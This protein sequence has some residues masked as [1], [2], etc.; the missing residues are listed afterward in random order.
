MTQSR[1]LST[2]IYCLILSFWKKTDLRVQSTRSSFLMTTSY[3]SRVQLVIVV[4]DLQSA[5]LGRVADFEHGGGIFIEVAVNWLFG[6]RTHKRSVSCDATPERVKAL[7]RTADAVCFDVDSTI[8]PI[9]GIDEIAAFCGV[10]KEVSEW[11][12]QAMGGNLPFKT[13]LRERLDIIRPTRTQTETFMKTHPPAL[14]KG[15]K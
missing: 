7:W 8:T 3:S 11:T 9:E 4:H 13:C 1:R 2:V 14:T 12:K 10:G 6:R 15:I 5:R